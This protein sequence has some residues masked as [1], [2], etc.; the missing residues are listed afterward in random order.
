MNP[1]RYALDDDDEENASHDHDRLAM[2]RQFEVDK[3]Q[4]GFNCRVTT[5]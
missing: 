5:C 4:Q 1:S 2:V 3:K